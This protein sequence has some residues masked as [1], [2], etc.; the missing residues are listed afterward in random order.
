MRF[1]I[2]DERLL[3]K[4]YTKG[5]FALSDTADVKEKTWA[6]VAMTFGWDTC[7]QRNVIRFFTNGFD[8]DTIVIENVFVDDPD[9]KHFV[10]GVKTPFNLLDVY[11]GF[12]AEFHA[13]N[14]ASVAFSSLNNCQPN[15]ALC[16]T[17]QAC[18][19][20]CGFDEYWDDGECK[21]CSWCCKEGCIRGDDYCGK[22]FESECGDNCLFFG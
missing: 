15:C 6:H 9:F 21:A 4:D 12:I 14:S 17:S 18:F 22:C 16:G 5:I 20:C 7:S 19:L 1:A 11:H 8:S 3:F 2:Y 13:H 10:G